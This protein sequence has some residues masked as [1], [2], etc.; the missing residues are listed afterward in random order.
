MDTLLL[1]NHVEMTTMY[2]KYVDVI[3]GLSFFGYYAVILRKT[4]LIQNGVSRIN[5]EQMDLKENF[6]K[7]ATNEVNPASV[8]I[9]DTSLYR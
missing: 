6:I 2:K 8:L 4:L 3:V 1:L 9:W 5:C 7:V